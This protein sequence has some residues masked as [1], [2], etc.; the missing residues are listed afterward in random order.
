MSS[1]EPHTGRSLQRRLVWQ[2]VLAI[3]LVLGAIFLLLDVMV[4][5]TMYQRLDDFLQ[6]RADGVIT[7]FADDDE[8]VTELLAAYDLAGHSEFFAVYGR[9]GRLRLASGN[10]LGRPLALP[11]GAADDGLRFHDTRL[12]DGHL[13]RALLS[14]LPDGGW[15][16]TATER[17]SWDRIEREMH[18]VLLAGMLL[19]TLLAVGLCLW[20]VNQ[21]FRTLAS[22]GGRLSALDPEQAGR[23]EVDHLPRE[24]QPYAGAVR[25]ALRRMREALQRER[26]FSRHVAHELRTPV[27]EVR[28]ASEHALREGGPQ[29]L[30]AGLRATLQANARMERGIQALLALSRWE[31]GLEA[32]QPDPLDLAALLRQMGAMVAA[33]HPQAL[34]LTLEVPASTWVH[35]DA[36]MLERILANLLHNA[37]DYGQ[38]EVPVRLLLEQDPRGYRIQ[39]RNAVDGLGP[40]D[41]A[42]FG[43]RYWRGGGRDGD[44]RHAGLGLA[45]SQAMATALGL[46]LDFGFEDG[47]VV[48]SLG[49]LAPL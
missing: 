20:L 47:E 4:D 18:L 16:L 19:A 36:G 24:L 28:M 34:P 22:E 48:A 12:P 1:P 46:Q 26:R 31:S 27:A 30:Q 45:L 21:V 17:E 7:L 42:R 33:S 49:H 32:P 40:D 11:E 5:R 6:A 43:E 29:A 39:V 25:D 38:P 3:G 2:L 44:Q 37:L 35:S 8:D 41:V 13:G 14:P 15:L 9:D 10:S 23:L